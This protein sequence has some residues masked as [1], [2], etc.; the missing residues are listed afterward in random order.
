MEETEAKRIKGATEV[1]VD[2]GAQQGMGKKVN[3]G[4]EKAI[5]MLTQQSAFLEHSL[6][7]MD[8]DAMKAGVEEA[9]DDLGETRLLSKSHVTIE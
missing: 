6:A 2:S 1:L 4:L 3:P 9:K 8:I 7:T 5:Q